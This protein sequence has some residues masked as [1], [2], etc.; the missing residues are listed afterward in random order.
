MGTW[1]LPLRCI[2][3]FLVALREG[4]LLGHAFRPKKDVFFLSQWRNSH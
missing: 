2:L 3:G 1:T 4:K